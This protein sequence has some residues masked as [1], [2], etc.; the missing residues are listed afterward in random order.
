ML[1]VFIV[2]VTV[3]SKAPRPL[4]ARIPALPQPVIYSFSQSLFNLPL[5]DDFGVLYY[6][7]VLDD[8][9]ILDGSLQYRAATTSQRVRVWASGIAKSGVP[10]FWESGA[11][12]DLS[13]PSSWASG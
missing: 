6:M 8:N 3:P 4:P 9:L 10:F 7:C 2:P 11:L 12:F 5:P 1:A 13:N